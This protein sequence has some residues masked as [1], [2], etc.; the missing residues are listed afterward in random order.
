MK[1]YVLKDVSFLVFE[2]NVEKI[3]Y[4]MRA[5]KLFLCSTFALPIVID[6]D[7]SYVNV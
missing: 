4:H 5:S 2:L 6:N 1:I 7:G 3:C